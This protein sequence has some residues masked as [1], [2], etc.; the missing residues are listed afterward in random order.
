MDVDISFRFEEENIEWRRVA[1]DY[2]TRGSK[3][4]LSSHSPSPEDPSMNNRSF[5]RWRN[6]IGMIAAHLR[7]VPPTMETI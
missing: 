6:Y 2:G 5:L 7:L 4:L 3:A 1:E